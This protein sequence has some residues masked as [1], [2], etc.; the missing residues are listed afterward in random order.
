M[1]VKKLTKRVIFVPI[2]LM[3]LWLFFRL[4]SMA[5]SLN[6]FLE[7]VQPL[8]FRPHLSYDQKMSLK[9]PVYFKYIAAV[10]SITSEN[11][12]I[13]VNPIGIP[14]GQIMWPIG[15]LKLTSA[16]LFPRKVVFYSE[17]RVQDEAGET[18]LLLAKGFPK[19]NVKAKSVYVI[20]DNGIK[21]ISGDYDP[22]KFKNQNGL[23][24]L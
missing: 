8:I 4:Q 19:E 1:T 13:Y 12:T 18:Y 22:G 14:Y 11:S 20:D 5:S 9:Y 3:S 21:E 15:Q 24:K 2:F 17:N 10:K 23:I 6:P 16:L 7:T